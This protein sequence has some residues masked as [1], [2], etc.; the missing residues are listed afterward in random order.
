MFNPKYIIISAISK[1]SKSS[2][3]LTSAP[4]SQ[5]NSTIS[6]VPKAD[7][8]LRRVWPT[9]SIKFT[10]IPPLSMASMR[11]SVSL[12]LMQSISWRWVFSPELSILLSPGRRLATVLIPDFGRAFRPSK[13]STS[14]RSTKRMVSSTQRSSPCRAFSMASGSSD[15]NRF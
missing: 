4:L 8:Q 2:P 12:L 14:N 5:R 9:S 13:S 6:W 7:A 10:S 15:L 1:T 3:L 11:A